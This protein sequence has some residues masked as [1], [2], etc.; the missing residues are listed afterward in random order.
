VLI[1]YSWPSR[2][3]RWDYPGDLGRADWTTPHFAGFLDLLA[4]TARGIPIHLLAHSMGT[5]PALAALYAIATE[6]QEPSR[7]RFGQIIFAAPDIDAEAFRQAVPAVLAL[8]SRV[9]LYT[10]SDLALRFSGVLSAHRRAGDSDRA[11]VLVAGMDTV[12]VTTVDAS[13]AHHDY[14]LENDHV[15]A[16]IFQLLS[17]GVPP[18]KRFRLFGVRVHGLMVWQFRS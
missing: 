3:S 12:D 14:F 4:S 17:Y 11:V 13:L 2:G 8:A 9:T 1:L 6:S 5:R 16:D 10:A 15:L 7:P 18:Q